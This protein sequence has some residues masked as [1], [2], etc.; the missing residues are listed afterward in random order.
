MYPFCE[1]KVPQ[2]PCI[3]AYYVYKTYIFKKKKK[4]ER[5]KN[6]LLDLVKKYKKG[7]INVPNVFKGNIKVELTS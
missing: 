7:K 2:P 1:C 3:A 4:K 6:W 5:K